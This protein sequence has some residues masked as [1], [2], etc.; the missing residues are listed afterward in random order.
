MGHLGVGPVGSWNDG[1]ERGHCLPSTP[2]HLSVVPLFSHHREC[3]GDRAFFG[4]KNK[5]ER[6]QVLL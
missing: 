4:K 6:K 1:S 3:L 2:S 5:R